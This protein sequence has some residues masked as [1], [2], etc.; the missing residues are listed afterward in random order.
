MT[1]KGASINKISKLLDVL[2]KH[3]KEKDCQHTP[4]ELIEEFEN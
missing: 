4:R 2:D 3:I 1:T